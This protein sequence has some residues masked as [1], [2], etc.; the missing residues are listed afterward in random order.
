M[1]ERASCSTRKEKDAQ[2][3][4]HP[5]LLNAVG[6]DARAFGGIA[7]LMIARRL[8]GVRGFHNQLRRVSAWSNGQT[9]PKTIQK[10]KNFDERKKELGTSQKHIV[11]GSKKAKRQQGPNRTKTK[12]DEQLSE[13][14]DKTK[15]LIKSRTH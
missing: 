8:V 2:T 1:S 6:I 5:K 7:S 10:A 4:A 15:R 9:T 13:K 12:K 3:K 14:L 11:R